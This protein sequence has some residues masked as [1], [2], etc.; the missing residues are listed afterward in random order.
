EGFAV[1]SLGKLGGY[2][3]NYSSDVDL[4]F[5]WCGSENADE[6][7]FFTRLGERLGFLLLQS[8]PGRP[9]FPVVMRL[10]PPR[11]TGPP[12]PSVSNLINYYES[13]GE[14]WER[15]ALIKARFVAGDRD[16]GRRFG[17]FVEKYTFARQMDDSSLEEIKRVK[18]RAEKEHALKADLK[19]GAGG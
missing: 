15:Q 6:L 11:T 18:H 4:V 5:L 13:W 12:G 7:R 17:D 3:L 8:G 10:P 16:L 19:Q 9:L 1:F 14:A 2:E